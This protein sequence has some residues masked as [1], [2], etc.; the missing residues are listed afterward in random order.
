MYRLLYIGNKLK[1][2]GK[3][4]TSV[5]T[6]SIQLGE[7][8]EVYAYSEKLNIVLRMLDIIWGIIKHRKE[9]DVILIDTYS[10]LNFY[11]SVVSVFFAQ[12]FKIDYYLYLHGGNLPERIKKSP[13]LSHY[14]FSNAKENIVPS[15]YLGEAFVKAGYETRFIPNNIELDRYPFKERQKARPAL[16]YVRSFSKVYNPQLA[17]KVFSK[18]YERYPEAVMCMVGPD[19][20]GTLQLCKE[21]AKELHVDK[22]ITFTGKLSKEEW[23]AR[24]KEYDIFVN[25]THF[26]NQPVSIIEAMAL[27]FPIVS[28]N[29]GGLPFLIE[30]AKEGL[31][32]ADNDEDCFFD[33]IIKLLEDEQSIKGMS[34]NA[35]KKAQEYE[36]VNVKKAW[37]NLF[38]IKEDGNV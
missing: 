34:H 21:L 8:M 11:I 1:K 23:I 17:I 10:S 26:D 24:S 31:L 7:F 19:K 38:G 37:K 25:P 14:I 2:H 20:D 22:R 15:G 6:L 28:T 5:D 35:L 9:A 16:L 29:V 36:W 4:P 12:L 3:T 18:L 33:A 30:D 27:G 13:K 32:C